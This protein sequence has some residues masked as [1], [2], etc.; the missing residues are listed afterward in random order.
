[1]YD[2]YGQRVQRTSSS[3]TSTYIYD[4]FGSLAA[5]YDTQA[6]PMT[7]TIYLTPDQLGSTRLVTSDTT[8]LVNLASPGS[9]GMALE[10]RDYLPFGEQL[11]VGRSQ[12]CAAA[13]AGVRQLYTG[14]ERDSETNLDFLNARYLSSPQGRFTSPDPDNAGA[15]LT[16]PQSWNMYSYAWN[17]PL[18]YVDPTGLCSQDAD[19]NYYDDGGQPCT[20][21]G[22]VFPGAQQ[23]NVN[24]N[25]PTVDS[26]GSDTSDSP[27]N[28]FFAFGFG[29]GSNGGGGGGGSTGITPLPGSPTN[30][31][32]CFNTQAFASTL[33][34]NACSTS[35]GPM[36]QVTFGL[37]F[38][39][40]GS[41][42]M[43]GQ[44]RSLGIMVHS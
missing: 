27:D 18:A 6:T 21:A 4:V 1:M 25:T 43:V 8:T 12:T 40:A 32:G 41:A 13:D 10:C 15:D 20:G 36:C 29:F 14:Q 24:S 9:P 26:S 33:D 19:G 34:Q 42:R 35:S 16:N 2:G 7:G 39:R 22:E 44:P 3:G 30:T 17:N 31:K 11:T 37:L 23:V 5:E 38:K 28:T